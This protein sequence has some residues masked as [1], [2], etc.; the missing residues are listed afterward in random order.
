M[1][2]AMELVLLLGPTQRLLYGRQTTRQPLCKTPAFEKGG[3][4]QC[5]AKESAIDEKLRLKGEHEETLKGY[6]DY[7]RTLDNSVKAVSGR[8]NWT[9][10]FTDLDAKM[11]KIFQAY[12]TLLQQGSDAKVKKARSVFR[13]RAAPARTRSPKQL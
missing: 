4:W 2:L 10:G 13:K 9:V 7:V 12:P 1:T 5:K 11:Q 3:Q 8:Q 6:A